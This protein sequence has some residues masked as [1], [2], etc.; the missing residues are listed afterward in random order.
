M[1]RNG[2][3]TN[4]PKWGAKCTSIHEYHVAD[5]IDVVASTTFQAGTLVLV[6][7]DLVRVISKTMPFNPAQPMW[8]QA[9][10]IP[11]PRAFQRSFCEFPAECTRRA[12]DDNPRSSPCSRGLVLACL[13]CLCSSA[14][15]TATFSLGESPVSK[16]IAFTTAGSC[17][18]AMSELSQDAMTHFDARVKAF[19]RDRAA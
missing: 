8:S 10:T 13:A 16:H 5:S 18:N 7:I 3:A 6:E 19:S 17:D 1:Q 2:R 11:C 4:I 12:S 9:T 15:L 14:A